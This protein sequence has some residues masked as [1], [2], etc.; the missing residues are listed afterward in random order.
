MI[1]IKENITNIYFVGDIHGEFTK[2][3]HDITYVHELKNSVVI[4]TGD[5]GFWYHKPGY[6]ER[7]WYRMKKRLEKNNNMILCV[8]GN[9]DNPWYYDPQN[10]P[11]YDRWKT[12]QDYEILDIQ[13]TKILCIGGATSIDQ[14]HRHEWNAKQEKYGSEKRIWWKSE[15]PL[16]VPESHLP[17]RVDVIVSHE[18]PIQ[19]GPVV[20]RSEDMELEVY[21]NICEDREYLGKVLENLKPRRWFFGHYHKSYS[22]T[23]AHSL[24]HGLGIHELIQYYGKDNYYPYLEYEDKV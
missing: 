10:W 7:I 15:R 5:S 9:H 20:Y 13:G 3:A 12:V 11:G 14:K 6:Y 23:Y 16:H 1:E 18:A 24:Y 8:R 17:T 22:G 19:V 2:L 4:I 21:R